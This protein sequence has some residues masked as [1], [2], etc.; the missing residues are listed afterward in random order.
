MSKRVCPICGSKHISRI[1]KESTGQLSM[2]TEFVFK[3]IIYKCASCKEM[4]DFFH[5]S[6]KFYMD[7]K[8]QAENTLVKQILEDLNNNGMSMAYIERVFELPARTLTR[9]K[10]GDY[11][12]SAL[13]L[14]KIIN[15][16]PWILEVA[17]NRFSPAVSKAIFLQAAM[18][19]FVNGLKKE[20]IIPK[21]NIEIKNPNQGSH[22]S[23][24]RK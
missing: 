22:S 4:G 13:A 3:E 1:E 9:W 6:D 11:S 21:Q 5:E 14:L 20:S 17:E 19:E 15:T 24:K 12:S 18:S 16:F 23:S 8:N 7:A 10:T 2:G